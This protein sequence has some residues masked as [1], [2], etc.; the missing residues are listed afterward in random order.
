MEQEE[1][2]VVQVVQV[3]QVSDSKIQLATHLHS[4]CATGRLL[5]Q[6]ANGV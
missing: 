5:W 3:V 6:R 1:A 4:Q 2:Q